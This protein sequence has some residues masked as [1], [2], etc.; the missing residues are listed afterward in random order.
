M[1]HRYLIYTFFFLLTAPLAAQSCDYQLILR[2]T[3]SGDGWNGGQLTVRIAGTPSVYTLASGG[4][5]SVFLSVRE[6]QSIELD[7]RRGAAPGEVSFQLLDNNDSL[8]YRAVSP[9]TGTNI[10]QTTAACVACAAPPLSSI[11]FFRVRF[12][13]VDVRLRRNPAADQA[14]Y[15][16]E[17]G[18][19]NFDPTTQDGEEFITGDNSF[20]ITGLEQERTYAFFVSTICDAS[21]TTSDR[22]GPFVI[23]TQQEI[24]LGVTLLQSPVTGCNVAGAPLTIGITNYGG[25]PQQFFRVGYAINS[26]EVA[27]N[28]P[29]DGIFTGIV[30]VDSTESFTFDDVPALRQPGSYRLKLYTRIEGDQDPSNDTLTISVVNQ[31]TITDFPYTENFEA[32][33]GLWVTGRA[34]RGAVSWAWGEPRNSLIDRAPQGEKAW[35]TSLFGDYFNG[36]ESYLISPCF[37]FTDMEDDPYFSCAL[38]VDTETDFDNLSL[39]MTT[40]DGENWNEVDI[41]PADI[42]WYNNR[43]DQVWEGDGGFSNGPRIVA[44]LLAG[45]AGE[46]VKL[47]FVFTSNSDDTR[48]GI[49]VD[50]VTI[51]SRELVDVAVLAVNGEGTCAPAEYEVSYTN[52]GT[53]VID[54]IYASIPTDGATVTDTIIGRLAPGN[55]RSFMFAQNAAGGNTRPTAI[56][57]TAP[58]DAQAANDTAFVTPRVTTSLPFYADFNDK[59]L[60]PRWVLG[61]GLGVAVGSVDGSPAIVGEASSSAA[62]SFATAFYG[63]PYRADDVLRFDLDFSTLA[64]ADTFNLEVRLVACDVEVATFTETNVVSGTYAFDFG[65]S[66]PEAGFFEF[67][68]VHVSGSATASFDNINV[69]RCP[70]DLGVSVDVIPTT[71]RGA[72]DARATATPSAGTA[73]YTYAWST[74]DVGQTITGLGFDDYTVTVTDRFGCQDVKDVVVR[75]FLDTE[76]PAGL[77]RSLEAHPNPTSGALRLSLELAELSEVTAEVYDATGRRLVSRSFGRT[78]SL[79][80]VLDLSAFV[81]GIYL[82]RV[83]ADGAARSI[84]V[85]RR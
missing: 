44:N 16:V 22:R 19:R 15:R 58:G 41:S 76:D 10:F 60:P 40:D 4:N 65:T 48:E 64:V 30:N 62:Y 54:T 34:G 24:D 52:V 43:P 83:R 63:G 12:N 25:A 81:P 21:G 42:N 2:D 7:Y 35:V 78:R 20:R 70:E 33:N 27:I 47:R 51:G 49:L 28:Y 68:L 75:N 37:D 17:Y 57:V 73:P 72:M 82:V 55:T 85:L 74:G 11:D 56:S 67:T 38:V 61:A 69:A 18:P 8:V 31:P 9:T 29:N 14:R 59:K 1:L 45:A 6:G 5:Q 13:S 80:E 32:N 26:K 50:A 39:E 36:E 66:T 71:T 46:V 84:R 79:R 77:L 3:V 23:T 53:S